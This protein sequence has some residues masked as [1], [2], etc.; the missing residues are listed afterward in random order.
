[1]AATI[2]DGKAIAA[3]IREPVLF[4]KREIAGLAPAPADTTGRDITAAA[5]GLAL[6]LRFSKAIELPFVSGRTTTDNEKTRSL[7][8]APTR[9]RAVMETALDRGITIA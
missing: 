2:I 9:P 5:L 3:T 8:V 1:M 7:L 4:V 6:E